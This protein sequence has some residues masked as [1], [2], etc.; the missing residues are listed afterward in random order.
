MNVDESR[1][2]L[3]DETVEMLKNA[4][5]KKNST[6]LRQRNENSS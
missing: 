3:K 4:I 5:R 2:S 6:P 1:R